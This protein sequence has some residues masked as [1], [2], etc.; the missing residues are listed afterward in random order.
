MSGAVLC[1]VQIH[2]IVPSQVKLTR[3]DVLRVYQSTISADNDLSAENINLGS[4]SYGRMVRGPMVVG[5]ALKEH[6]NR[7]RASWPGCSSAITAEEN[8][9]FLIAPPHRPQD[10]HACQV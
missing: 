8:F 9:L 4:G 10:L 1:S 6:P 2:R 3:T 5:S 7:E